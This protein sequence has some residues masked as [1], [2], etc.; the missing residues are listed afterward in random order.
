MTDDWRRLRRLTVNEQRLLRRHGRALLAVALLHVLLTLLLWWLGELSLA[1]LTVVIGGLLLVGLV[2]LLL[3][4]LALTTGWREPSL[5]MP[6]ALL[7]LAALLLTAF[8]LHQA[9]IS[10]MMLFFPL[11]LLVSFRLGAGALLILALLASAGYGLML[12]TA[13]RDHGA[14]LSLTLEALQWLVF[15]LVSLSFAITGSGVNG[16]RRRLAVKNLALADAL[17]QVR[18]LAI[19]DDLTGLFNRRHI[20]EVLERQKG[21]ADSGAQPF[22]VCYLDLDHFKTIND[23]FGHGWGDRVLRDFA[24][25]VLGDLRDGDYLARLGG[26]EFLV[27]LPGSDLDGAALVAER[28][29]QGWSRRDFRLLNGP[30]EVSFSAGVACYHGGETI[31]Q[32]IAR[33]DHAL[34]L[35]KSQGR[36][37]VCRDS[38]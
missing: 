33:A 11:L 38:S 23:A 30:T 12:A 17:E 1:T 6:V 7:M 35:A 5:S 16:L 21:L 37:R 2:Y 4:E 26:E 25:F 31:D 18:D 9:R 27:V 32:L 8:G 13:W 15:T 28:L 3:I 19:R 22:S 36:N 29:R 10:A 24:D 14:R 20:M 34:Y